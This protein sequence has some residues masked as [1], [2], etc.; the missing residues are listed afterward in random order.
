MTN[1]KW[2]P[3][4]ILF[5]SIGL[6]VVTIAINW[7]V[8]R[9]SLILIPERTFMNEELYLGEKLTD[10]VQRLHFTKMSMPEPAG[11]EWNRRVGDSI[12]QHVD[13]SGSDLLSRV[14]R[15][16]LFERSFVRLGLNEVY[17]LALGRYK[18]LI[19]NHR[20]LDSSQFVSKNVVLLYA[21]VEMQSCKCRIYVHGDVG[22]MKD[23][24]G[25]TQFDVSRTYI[26]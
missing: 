14:Y 4:R 19:G 21:L 2:W 7:Y 1:R 12:W 16:G 6:T 5:L 8:S 25:R 11:Y 18:R 9:T 20:I 23:E 24:Y 13:I 10:A 26:Y 22:N 17:Q 3:S 15:I